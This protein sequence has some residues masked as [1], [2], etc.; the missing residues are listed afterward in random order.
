M[1]QI[2]SENGGGESLN[3]MWKV[4]KDGSSLHVQH[5]SIQKVER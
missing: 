5:Y 3:S 4:R 2:M 1:S